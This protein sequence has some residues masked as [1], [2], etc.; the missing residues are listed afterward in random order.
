[1]ND[2]AY[3]DATN[4]AECA[5]LKAEYIRLK[6]DYGASVELLFA[7]GY[8][9]TD[10]EWAALKASTV[11]AQQRSEAAE[12]RLEKH[13]SSHASLGRWQAAG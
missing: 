13:K 4:C 5:S 9:V 3:Q 11:E 8:Q 10:S 12:F 1:M 6:Q 7:T 2:K